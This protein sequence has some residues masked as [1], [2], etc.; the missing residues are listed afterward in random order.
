M[1]AQPQVDDRERSLIARV[2][3][4]EKELFYELVRP[5]ERRVYLAALSV[6][7][8]EA[9]AEE[10]AQE[11][12]LKALAHLAQFRSQA[13]FSTWLVQIT[14]NEARM[15]RRK[16]RRHLYDSIDAEHTGEE[17]DYTPRDFADWREIPAEAL[18]RKEL[19]E[20]LNRAIKALKPAYREVLVLRDV[21]GLST[22]EASRVLGV[23][24]ANVRTR[25]LRA[26]LMM[27]DHLAPGF[28]GA[29]S[30]GHKGWKQVRPW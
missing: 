25:L 8:N 30:T 6:L 1:K 27:R 10:V 7:G 26:R 15:R 24:E 3:A 11:A 2:C 4:G 21:Q 28:D 5:H 14:I 12:V 9:D 20:A 17:G 13:K 18:E 29:W 22:V 19:V 16:D 23:S